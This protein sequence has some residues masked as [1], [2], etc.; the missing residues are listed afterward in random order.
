MLFLFPP[1]KGE[2]RERE[3]AISVS[4]RIPFVWAFAL[5]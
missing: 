1:T 4:V 2:A 3:G 5:A